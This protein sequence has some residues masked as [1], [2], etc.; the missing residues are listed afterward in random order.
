MKKP[1]LKIRRRTVPLS[2]WAEA[3]PSKAMR[4]TRPAFNPGEYRMVFSMKC[5]GDKDGRVGLYPRNRMRG[6]P[7]E[8]FSPAQAG[9]LFVMIGAGRKIADRLS[10]SGCEI[11][12]LMRTAGGRAPRPD[13]AASA[14]TAP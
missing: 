8:S 11:A 2:A 13:R 12:R 4:A 10:C 5:D 7:D 9:H 3:A 14:C 6:I 1:A